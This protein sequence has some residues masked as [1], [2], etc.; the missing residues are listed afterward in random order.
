[1]SN[2]KADIK[3]K[4]NTD[5]SQNVNTISIKNNDN[6]EVDIKP[7]ST[8]FNSISKSLKHSFNDDELKI[9]NLLTNLK[10]FNQDNS[11]TDSKNIHGKF[12]HNK[13]LIYSEIYDALYN[14]ID[15]FSKKIKTYTIE[16]IKSLLNIDFKT[17][18]NKEKTNIIDLSDISNIV[19]DLYQI[20]P[21]TIP[22]TGKGEIAMCV[23]FNDLHKN[24]DINNI[25]GDVLLGDNETIEIKGVNARITGQGYKFKSATFDDDLAKFI[26][27][28]FKDNNIKLEGVELDKFNF[29]NFSDQCIRASDYHGS[30]NLFWNL[31]YVKSKHFKLEHLLA[32]IIDQK[33]GSATIKDIVSFYFEYAIKNTEYTSLD[34]PDFTGKNLTD[35][36]TYVNNIMKICLIEHFEAHFKHLSKRNCQAICIFNKKRTKILIIKTIEEFKD[37]VTSDHSVL[38]ITNSPKACD[39][40][41]SQGKSYSISYI[42]ESSKYDDDLFYISLDDLI[43]DCEVPEIYHK[44]DLGKSKDTFEMKHIISFDRFIAL[45]TH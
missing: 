22:T 9:E 6:K 11:D 36:G 35:I 32:K 37:L 40:S 10:T 3:I 23:L 39:S 16:N 8:M 21:T 24:K 13:Q 28:K 2:K 20:S 30:K 38:K 7:G 14:N 19:N 18:L 33:N 44:I 45:K 31:G 25:T 12:K 1:M 4:L 26:F 43:T 17:Y 29:N 34:K 15:E 5:I 42:S 41:A 27:D